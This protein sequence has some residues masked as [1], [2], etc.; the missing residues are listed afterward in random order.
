[1]I[2]EASVSNLMVNL[3]KRLANFTHHHYYDTWCKGRLKI[4]TAKPP[5]L[6]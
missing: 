3:E 2:S 5:K 6:G 1:M 4:L